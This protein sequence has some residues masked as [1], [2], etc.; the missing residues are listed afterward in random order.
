MYIFC[1]CV[2]HLDKI[3]LWPY[4]AHMAQ[5]PD[6]PKMGRPPV[7]ESDRRTKIIKVLAT[8]AELAELQQAASMASM[9]VSTWMRAVA[10]E[11]ARHAF[12]HSDG[13][14]KRR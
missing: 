6:P 3:F 5:P 10:L 11:K 1:P 2:K 7:A 8:E 14:A 9:T 13:S 12:T 4:L